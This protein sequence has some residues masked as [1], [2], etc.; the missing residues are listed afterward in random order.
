MI[1]KVRTLFCH[2][3]IC[4]LTLALPPSSYSQPSHQWTRRYNGTGN[5]TDQVTAMVVDAAGNV[6]VT[7]NSSSS[8]TTFTEDYV[9]IK[10]SPT[11]DSLWAQRYNGTG[12]SAD[13]PFD[14]ALDNSGNIY[15]TGYSVG[16]GANSDYLTIKYN[17]SGVQQWV[18]RYN[19]PVSGAGQDVAHAIAVDGSGNVYITGVSD[20]SRVGATG[21]CVTIKYNTNGVQQWIAMYN[22]AG[23][24]RDLGYD[25][26]VDNSGNVYVTGYTTISSTNLD[27][28]TIK[29]DSSG[30]MLWARTYDG[31]GNRDITQAIAVDA[32]GNVYVTGTSRNSSAS[33]SEDYL[34]IKY[35][36]NGDTVWTR[37]YNGPQNYGDG[38]ED[39]AVD[40]AGNVYVT[41]YG[42]NGAVVRPATVKYGTSGTLEWA[43]SYADT[44][45]AYG[46]ALDATGNV[47]VTGAVKLY[48]RCFIAKYNSAGVQQWVDVYS[49]AGSLINVGYK[50]TIDNVGNILVA[51]N[52]SVIHG[53]TPNT[54][55]MVM[56][57][58][59]GSTDVSLST[60]LPSDFALRQNYPNP[61]NPTTHFGFRIANF[62]LVTLKVFDVLGREVATLVNENLQAGSY[63]KTFDAT[64][65]ASGIYIYRL[66]AG[67]Q[68]ISKKLLLTK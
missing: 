54:D 33:Y 8:N 16:N 66:T 45:Y 65:L 39:M 21:N 55:F 18:Q 34:T 59:Q 6:Y 19:G 53:S 14:I 4:I 30:N 52:S 42:T 67:A 61:F 68:S 47:Y 29:Y 37:R 11:G 41:G 24:M 44:A 5:Y 27:Y 23:N 43:S 36:V 56:K 9:T 26:A 20:T 10:Y 31:T 2:L 28:L 12:N 35:D 63:E 15:V 38:V 40:I 49:D 48:P 1:M 17:A 60:D 3:A 64:G 32:G 58:T 62:G 51:G 46:L 13:V 25:I 50:V 7:G 57:Y 22:G